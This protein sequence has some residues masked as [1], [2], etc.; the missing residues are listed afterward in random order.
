[1]VQHDT[2]RAALT[3][4]D[5]SH[6]QKVSA[7]KPQGPGRQIEPKTRSAISRKSSQAGT[8]RHPGPYRPPPT[9]RWIPKAPSPIPNPPCRKCAGARG[10]WPERSVCLDGADGVAAAGSVGSRPQDAR[11][12]WLVD[13]PVGWWSLAPTAPHKPVARRRDPVSSDTSITAPFRSLAHA[14]SG[15]WRGRCSGWRPHLS[16]ESRESG[17]AAGLSRKP[18]ARAPEHETANWPRCGAG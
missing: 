7:R 3:A 15:A 18:P 11:R 16:R 12:F 1:M 14:T 13:D 2:T 6:H 8:Q 5:R 17:R 10:W 4:Q 9:T